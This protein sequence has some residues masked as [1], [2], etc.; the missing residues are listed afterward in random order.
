MAPPI[1]TR[2]VTVV[3]EGNHTSI[4]TE[5]GIV[6]DFDLQTLSNGMGAIILQ[7]LD[8]VLNLKIRDVDSF[9]IDVLMDQLQE[10]AFTFVEDSEG[11]EFLKE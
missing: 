4:N 8:N 11:I 10:H 5:V 3:Q 2:G 7:V 1:Q 9:D 6:K